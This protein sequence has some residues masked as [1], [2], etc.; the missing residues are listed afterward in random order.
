MGDRIKNKIKTTG[1]N[2]IP[3]KEKKYAIQLRQNIGYAF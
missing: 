2:G 1:F 3:I